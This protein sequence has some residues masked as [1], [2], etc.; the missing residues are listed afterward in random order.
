MYTINDMPKPIDRELIEML[1]KVET[2]TVGHVLYD[3][4]VGPGI[5]PL[6]PDR[7]VAGTAVTLRLVHADSTLLHYLT[8][9]VR[10]GD[11]ILI[12]RCGDQRYAC[13]G[14]GVT[15][16]MKLAGVKA[17]IVDGP[18]TDIADIRQLNLPV[19]SRGLSPVTTRL[20]DKFGA[21][22][23]PVSIGGKIVHPGDAVLAD[24]CG[25]L[26]LP[27]GEVRSIAQE[28]L[29]RQ[30]REVGLIE[31]LRSGEKLPDIS[32]ATKQVEAKIFAAGVENANLQSR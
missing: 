28:A 10:P 13:W 6:I 14:G 8:K 15:H 22:N 16:A 1:E 3:A 29:A 2:A 23:V 25:I 27:P 5:T 31:R 30:E 11:I 32:G 12:D 20:L 19:W 26:V 4:F 18:A 21:L 7:R 9:L 24:E 17:G